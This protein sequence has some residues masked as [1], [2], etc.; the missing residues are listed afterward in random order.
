MRIP[1]TKILVGGASQNIGDEDAPQ[2]FS[3]HA[4]SDLGINF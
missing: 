3:R 1:M 4:L 2:M